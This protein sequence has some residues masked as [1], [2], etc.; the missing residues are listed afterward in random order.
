[1]EELFKL[2]KQPA[3]IEN[4]TKKDMQI[5]INLPQVCLNVNLSNEKIGQW[6]GK[7]AMNM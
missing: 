2:P 5:I 6:P 1:M 7:P 4:V 3:K